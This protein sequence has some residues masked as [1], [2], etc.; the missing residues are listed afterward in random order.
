MFQLIYSSVITVDVT[1]DQMR[2]I[3]LE[4][5]A[6]NEA[7]NLTGALLVSDRGILQILEGDEET[8][9][10]VYNR[11]KKDPRHM[12]CE[13]LLARQ[14]KAREFRQMAMGFC[15][16]SDDDGYEVKMAIMALKARRTERQR[17]DKLAS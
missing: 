1:Q 7:A 10:A 14:C 8:V 4:S 12:G 16:A 11:I 5:R 13:I 15:K 6:S 2:Q 9:R 17:I 3:A